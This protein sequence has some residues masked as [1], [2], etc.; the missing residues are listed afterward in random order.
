MRALRESSLIRRDTDIKEEL[1]S[2][3]A[4]LDTHLPRN[5][6]ADISN[7]IGIASE[8]Q[9]DPK[10]LKAIEKSEAKEHGIPWGFLLIV[11]DQVSPWRTV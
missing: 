3:R 7:L 1:A 6:R 5:R 4:W 8:E 2:F 11:K 10:Q 9:I